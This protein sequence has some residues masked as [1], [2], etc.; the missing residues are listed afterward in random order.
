MSLIN[1]D[2]DSEDDSIFDLIDSDESDTDESEP[3]CIDYI[4]DSDD[5]VVPVY[6]QTS[7]L[8][9][10][11]NYLQSII[12]EEVTDPLEI[13]MNLILQDIINENK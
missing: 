13:R 7:L 3:D 6:Q 4:S 12:E 8:E 11:N 9:D 1:F 10:I 5:T 2:S